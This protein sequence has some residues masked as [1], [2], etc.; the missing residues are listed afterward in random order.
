MQFKTESEYIHPLHDGRKRVCYCGG[1]K[2]VV[3]IPS[4]SPSLSFIPPPVG[5][6]LRDRDQRR[7]RTCEED[8]EGR[9]RK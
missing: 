2:R 9:G 6:N 4:R 7:G 3:F 1:E 5:K 8:I